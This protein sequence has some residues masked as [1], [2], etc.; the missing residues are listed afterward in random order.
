MKILCVDTTMDGHIV[1]G[2]HTFL[3]QL[4]AGLT[5][6]GREVH[7]LSKGDPVA[8]SAAGIENSGSVIHRDVWTG[9]VL[10]DD[11]TPD[12]AKWVNDLRPD[13]YVVSV[14]SDIGWT[15]MPYL[16]PRIATLTI[17][18]NDQETFYAPVRHY[19]KFLT[20]AIGVSD[21]ICRKYVDE[22]GMP[23]DGVE[24]IPYGVETSDAAPWTSL[25]GPL[26]LV[27]VGRFENEQKRISDVVAVIKKLS[28]SG[29]DFE[30]DLV[31]DGVEMPNV[32]SA[33]SGFDNVR[34]HG[35]LEAERVIDTMR[36]SEVVLLASAYEGFCISLTEAM[37]N[38]CTPV[39]SDIRS[40]NKQLVRDG[41]NG[42]VVTIGDVDAF[43]ARIR[44]LA[45]DRDRL[46]VMRRAAWET[47]REY[48][49]DRMVENY[50]SCFERA[51]EDARSNPRKQDANFP[52]MESCRSRYPLWLR[53]IKA[54]VSSF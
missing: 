4:M 5:D 33:L 37:A 54:R 40:G 50:V 29:I 38:G 41:E 8:K 12:V 27:Y 15:I 53:R 10:V 48:G 16:D 43:V 23:A 45:K 44:A 7:F 34:I 49:I 28:E 32:R 30:F 20:R 17:G 21:E 14:S 25:T 24:W 39:V 31:G 11:A 46:S 1:G 19:R 26:R 36:A 9:D 18:H 6:A 3:V 52:L 42:Y 47:G 22:C 13:V 2:A 51:I 35:W